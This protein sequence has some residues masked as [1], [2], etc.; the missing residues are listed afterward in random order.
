MADI[1]LR[2][3]SL[4]EE[5]KKERKKK[6]QGKNVMSASDTQGGHKKATAAPTAHARDIYIKPAAITVL[7]CSEVKK[8]KKTFS[9]RPHGCSKF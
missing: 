3:L 7:H 6:P 8:Q 2:R 4:G 5:R 1:Q 9:S